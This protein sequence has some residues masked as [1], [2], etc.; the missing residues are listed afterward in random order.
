[1]NKKTW[2]K[3]NGVN[4]EYETW[5]SDKFIIMHVKLKSC[6]IGGNDS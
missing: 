6:Y 5:L 4:N 1:M 2:K 3:Q